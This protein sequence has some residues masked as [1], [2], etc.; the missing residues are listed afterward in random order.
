MGVLGMG[1]RFFRAKDP[2]SLNAWCLGLCEL[3]A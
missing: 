3:P 1:G 2:D